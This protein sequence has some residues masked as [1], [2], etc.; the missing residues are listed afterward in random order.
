MKK[1]SLYA[2]FFGEKFAPP[3]I[4]GFSERGK[5]FSEKLAPLR[6]YSAPLLVPSS[7]NSWNVTLAASLLDISEYSIIGMQQIFYFSSCED[8]KSSNFLIV[9]QGERLVL[10]KITNMANCRFFYF[11]VFS[12]KYKNHDVFKF[13]KMFP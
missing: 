11:S 10:N 8:V 5:P 1:V 9:N 6:A 3:K 13:S 7:M 4:A 2:Y 12:Q